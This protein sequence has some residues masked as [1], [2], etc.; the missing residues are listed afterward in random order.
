MAGE[1]APASTHARGQEA[2][3]ATRQP[4]P[5]GSLA[6]GCAS[7]HREALR[8]VSMTPPKEISILWLNAGLSCDGD[9]IAMT[10]ATQPSI[11]DVLSGAIPWIPK[12]ILYNAVSRAR[13]W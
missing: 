9:T 1:T 12:V 3:D 10:G 7:P 13:K 6:A 4:P 5:P 8:L 2:L 11:E